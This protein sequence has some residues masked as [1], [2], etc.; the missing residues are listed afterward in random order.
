MVEGLRHRKD[1]RNNAR[2]AK[3]GPSR[4]SPSR[5]GAYTLKENDD[6]WWIVVTEKRQV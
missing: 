4:S 2:E 5:E 3:E 1:E 6:V